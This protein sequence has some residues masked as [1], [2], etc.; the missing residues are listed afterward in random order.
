MKGLDV[1]P[2]QRVW[3]T[4]SRSDADM[5][6]QPLHPSNRH[7]GAG[8]GCVRRRVSLPSSLVWKHQRRLRHVCTRSRP[9][10]AKHASKPQTECRRRRR[11]YDV[12]SSAVDAV[13]PCHYMRGDAGYAGYAME[14]GGREISSWYVLVDLSHTAT[15]VWLA[16][17]LGVETVRVEMHLSPC[18]SFAGRALRGP[19][20]LCLVPVRLSEHSLFAGGGG[21]ISMCADF[22]SEDRPLAVEKT[23]CSGNKISSNR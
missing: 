22:V 8:G 9:G 3:S 18:K 6:G 12:S 5:S 1:R 17:R 20:C 16:S 13:F 15:C 11:L 4:P 23:T 2:G 21:G 19:L 10:R 14:K 7:V